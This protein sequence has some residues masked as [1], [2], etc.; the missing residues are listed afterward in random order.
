MQHTRTSRKAAPQNPDCY[1]STRL[2]LR[3]RRF[4]RGGAGGQDGQSLVPP[5]VCQVTMTGDRILLL[6]LL[7][8]HTHTHT[9]AKNLQGSSLH[10]WTSDIERNSD[11]KLV[12]HGLALHQPELPN[13]IPVVCC[14]Y[15]IRIVQFTC[16]N[17]RI[18]NLKKG[19]TKRKF[20]PVSAICR[21]LDKIFCLCVIYKQITT[22]QDATKLSQWPMLNNPYHR[23]T[24]LTKYC[25]YYKANLCFL[26]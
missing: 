10:I 22:V 7:H 14:V 25:G 26:F 6:L 20:I 2:L 17:Q 5:S 9:I 4:C 3:R 19:K 23:T 15:D 12:W 16:F 1:T 24:L 13:V 8:T 21:I 18:V 11:I